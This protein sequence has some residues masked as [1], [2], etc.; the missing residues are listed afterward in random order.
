MTEEKAERHLK[1][2]EPETVITK[3]E[4]SN[5]V[6]NVPTSLLNDGSVVEVQESTPPVTNPDLAQRE[7]ETD[8]E[9]NVRMAS[10]DFVQVEN[11]PQELDWWIEALPEAQREQLLQPAWRISGPDTAAWAEERYYEIYTRKKVNDL[12]AENTIEQLEIEIERVKKRNEERN[13][14]FV[15]ALNF[16]G[17]HLLDYVLHLRQQD[18]SVKSYKGLYV[19]LG[20]RAT[21]A[22]F[23]I[24]DEKAF[25]KWLQDNEKTAWFDLVV[26]PKKAEIKKGLTY[27]GET[28]IDTATGA[29]IE[30]AIA[31]PAVINAS[32]E[33]EDETKDG[34]P[35]LYP[36]RQLYV[37]Q[38]EQQ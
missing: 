5:A 27:D 21:Q 11:Q 38:S 28:V 6:V 33:I 35:V 3:V 36:I 8:E 23:E 34:K 18:D 2:A 9:Y 7:G 31:K 14:P 19:T 26:K 29:I 32:I 25:T 30:G 22:N 37:Y 12:Q 17:N 15:R 10:T 13:E 16:F 1:V 20:T 4:S 24:I